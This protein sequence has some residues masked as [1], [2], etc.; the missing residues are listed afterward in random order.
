VAGK[1]E[2]II[3][4]KKVVTVFLDARLQRWLFNVTYLK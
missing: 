4:S 3:D 2:L 1:I